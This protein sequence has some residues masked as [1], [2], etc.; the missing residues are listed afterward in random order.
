MEGKKGRGPGR[1]G[2]GLVTRYEPQT[3][4]SKALQTLN[5]SYDSKSHTAVGPRFLAGSVASILDTAKPLL[6]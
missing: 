2:S 5:L 6:G 3:N 1:R 4:K